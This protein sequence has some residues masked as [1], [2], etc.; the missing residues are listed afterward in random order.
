MRD[1]PPRTGRSILRRSL[2]ALA[3]GA[4]LATTAPL[5]SADELDDQRAKVGAEIGQLGSQR[6]TL[7]QAIA[8]QRGVVGQADASN[9]AAIR[10]LQEAETRL[11]GAQAE[12]AAAESQLAESEA[13]DRQRQEELE[14]AEIAL[15]KA[16]ADVAAAQA[17]Y[18]SLNR[19]I[20]REVSLVTQQNGP[21]VNLALL[22]TDTD[23]ASLHRNAQLGDTLFDVSAFELDE[24]ERLRFQ[25]DEA[26][27]RADEAEQ[28]AVE[29][30]QA[31]A[32]QLEVSKAAR[33]RAAD[34]EASVAELVADRDA[35]AQA[36]SAVL[37]EEQAV[38]AS[39]EADAA[40][41]EQ[42]IQQRMAD[43]AAL[44]GKIAERDRIRAE[45]ARKAREAEAKRQREA[46]ARKKA[47]AAKSKQSAPSR[48]G[49]SSSRSES[50]PAP[51]P[52]PDPVS[53]GSWSGF[54]RPAGRISSHYGMRVHPVTG[55]YK[56]HDGT[57]FA[58]SC[59]TPLRAADDGVVT[60]RYYNRGYG[61][62]LM[63]DHGRVNGYNVTTGY[64]HA[65]RYIV[66]V[67][68]RVKKGQTIGYVGNT[69]YSTGCHLHLMVWENGR[70]VNPM[71][72]W[73]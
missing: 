28:A 53:S 45:E 54:V 16:R 30:R 41:V 61:N 43:A 6:T 14:A 34:L 4:M 12:L 10:A 57:D 39:M 15:E 50:R 67:G 17:A 37:Q 27:R 2:A 48:G 69:G 56:L 49:S 58:A 35:A 46:A 36:A 72:R 22:L 51:K 55:I 64:N 44:D 5:A 38:Q 13:L 59:G 65:S 32:E 70:V 31:A 19:R 40:A 3:V 1:L 25:L 9:A 47:A 23:A 42:R 62:R 33:Q 68:Q 8:A 71:N 26:E 21:L 60:Q 7:Q 29:A 52:K 66:G 20:D 73:F 18:D 24:A 63:I 11:A